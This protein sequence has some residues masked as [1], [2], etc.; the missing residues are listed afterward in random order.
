MTQVPRRLRESIQVPRGT[1]GA[2]LAELD[3]EL[4]EYVTRELKGELPKI[5]KIGGLVRRYSLQL[6]REATPRKLV[7]TSILFGSIS[8]MPKAGAV[9]KTIGAS[10][11]I[12]LAILARD[13]KHI[14]ETE[15]ETGNRL[16]PGEPGDEAPIKGSDWLK[17][18]ALLAGFG[19]FGDVAGFSPA[20]RALSLAGAAAT[21]MVGALVLAAESIDEAAIE[22]TIIK[23]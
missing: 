4:Q 17:A 8:M 3:A 14:E 6:P 19:I 1:H 7:G 2:D 15:I 9:S 23:G 11:A 16:K 10:T 18:S 5:S 21:G 12:G 20:R 22:D 13:L